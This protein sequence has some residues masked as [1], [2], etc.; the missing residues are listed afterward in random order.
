MGDKS[1]P[2][3]EAIIDIYVKNVSFF[4]IIRIALQP[5]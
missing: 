2:K 5:L 4:G 3:I 1:R